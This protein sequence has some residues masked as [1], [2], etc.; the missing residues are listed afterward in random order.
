[1]RQLAQAR[2]DVQRDV[3]EQPVRVALHLKVAEQNVRLEQPQR[4]INDVLLS[5]G[6]TPFSVRDEK[7]FEKI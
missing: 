4:L 6:V 1:V 3:H 2:A 7:K 5:C